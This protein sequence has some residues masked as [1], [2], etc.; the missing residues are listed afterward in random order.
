MHIANFLKECLLQ[1]KSCRSFILRNL[2]SEPDLLLFQNNPY[3]VGFKLILSSLLSAQSITFLKF[4]FKTEEILYFYISKKILIS[5]YKA[6]FKFC[7][8]VQRC[9]KEREYFET[10]FNA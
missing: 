6:F 10:Y 4:V 2:V 8:T 1:A 9:S 5:I 7:V 3:T